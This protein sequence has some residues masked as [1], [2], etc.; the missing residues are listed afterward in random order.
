MRGIRCW[1]RIGQLASRFGRRLTVGSIGFADPSRVLYAAGDTACE[2]YGCQATP[3][4]SLTA[5][6]FRASC[7]TYRR[8]SRRED[9]THRI[10]WL[11]ATPF[12]M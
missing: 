2:D 11:K 10:G 5:G 12:V 9:G 8:P 7:Q 1:H 6:L 4:P 3:G